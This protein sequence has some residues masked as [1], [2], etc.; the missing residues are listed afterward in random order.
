MTIHH[1]KLAYGRIDCGVEELT[2]EQVLQ[3]LA[4]L[5]EESG[6]ELNKEE[7]SEEDEL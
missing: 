5:N 3:M 6:K 7:V 2:E 4:E 1:D